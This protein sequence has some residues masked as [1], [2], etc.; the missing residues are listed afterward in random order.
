MLPL[1]QSG[2]TPAAT[3]GARNRYLWRETATNT[4]VA[5]VICPT[6]FAATEW[7]TTICKLLQALAPNASVSKTISI[8][9][10]TPARRSYDFWGLGTLVAALKSAVKAISQCP[11]GSDSILPRARTRI[12]YCRPAARDTGPGCLAGIGNWSVSGD[13]RPP[14]APADAA[15]PRERECPASR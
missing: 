15:A 2:A 1:V 13:R 4:G 12:S 10:R 6:P 8:P 7:P 5:P 14:G 3:M 11:K 9:I